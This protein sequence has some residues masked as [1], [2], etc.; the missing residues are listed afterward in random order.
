MKSRTGRFRFC[1]LVNGL[2]V[3]C[4]DHANTDDGLNSFAVGS[5]QEFLVSR[6]PA[7]QVAM[8]GRGKRGTQI[9]QYCLDCEF[10]TWI[11]VEII[12][13]FEW[14]ALPTEAVVEQKIKRFQHRALPGIVWPKN[15]RASARAEFD[16]LKR[17]KAI[18]GQTA[19]SHLLTVGKVE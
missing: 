17:S 18:Y 13:L 3:R 9:A 12:C 16:M 10:V 2:E 11:T 1:E 19:N 7:L 5:G 8:N 14:W 15:H 6:A 4:A